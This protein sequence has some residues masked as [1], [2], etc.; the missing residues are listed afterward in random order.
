MLNEVK[1]PDL[2][3]C[4]IEERIQRLKENGMVDQIYHVRH[5]HPPSE[6]LENTPFTTILRSQFVREVSECWL[7]AFS[8]L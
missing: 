5:A 1:M 7:C 4:T 8:Y 2:L 6:S 3:W